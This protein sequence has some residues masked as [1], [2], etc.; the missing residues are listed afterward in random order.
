MSAKYNSK[1]FVNPNINRLPQPDA[2]E[3][4]GSQL[5]IAYCTIFSTASKS[6]HR[7]KY[8][9]PMAVAPGCEDNLELVSHIR[10]IRVY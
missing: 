1:L 6:Q 7:E 3:N 4:V 8:S 9:V 2:N 10:A 5:R